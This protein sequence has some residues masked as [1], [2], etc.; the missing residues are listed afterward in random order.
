MLGMAR[1]VTSWHCRREKK[2]RRITDDILECDD[3]GSLELLQLPTVHP[4]DVKR[5]ASR[6]ARDCQPG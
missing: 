1:N 6:E 5:E 2:I 4:L 3:L